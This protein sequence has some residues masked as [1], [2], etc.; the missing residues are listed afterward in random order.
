VSFP[1][2][3]PSLPGIVH[4]DVQVDRARWH[5]ATAGDGPPIV[6]L[7]GWPQHWWIW[8]RVIPELAQTH[9]VYAPDMRGFGWSDAPAGRYSKMGLACDVEKL[10]DALDIDSCTLVGHDWGG[11]VSFLT[12]LRAPERVER[13]IGFSIIHPW[14]K[15]SRIDPAAVLKTAAYQLP[16]AAPVLG[17]YIQRFGAKAL[18]QLIRR[19]AAKN[20]EWDP[21]DVALYAESFQR[22]E[23]ARAASALYRTFLTR[24]LGPL[25]GGR[26]ANRRLEMPILLATGEHDAIVTPARLAGYEDHAPNMRT[27]VIQG[28]GHFVLDEQPMTALRLI[29]E[30]LER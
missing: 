17:E 19:G 3:P 16:V 4:T 26:Y 21:Q 24:E 18:G 7:H 1:A 8:R 9:R 11:F 14:P 6:L 27:Q 20:F 10:L 30:E 22:P 2:S 5:V 23:H 15:P 25:V 28:V 29:R 12:A 13:L